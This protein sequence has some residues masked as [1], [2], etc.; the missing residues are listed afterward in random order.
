MNNQK[1]VKFNNILLLVW[2]LNINHHTF[3]VPKNRGGDSNARRLR[4]RN[5][6]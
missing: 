1:N 4:Y 5:R 2:Q 6:K 3:F